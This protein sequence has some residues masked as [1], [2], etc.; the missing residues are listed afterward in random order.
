M[1]RLRL[2]DAAAAV[3]TPIARAFRMKCV[4]PATRDLRPESKCAKRKAKWNAL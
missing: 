3:A 4:D 2:G 1:K